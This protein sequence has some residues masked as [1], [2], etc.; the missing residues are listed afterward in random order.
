M[1][2]DAL[3]LTMGVGEVRIK[4]MRTLFSPK[5]AAEDKTSL[6]FGRSSAGSIWQFLVKFFFIGATIM[7]YQKPFM[8]KNLLRCVG[9]N[10]SFG[11]RNFS[12]FFV[13]KLIPISITWRKYLYEV[14]MISPLFPPTFLANFGDRKIQYMAK[15]LAPLPPPFL[16]K[17]F[18][19]V[20]GISLI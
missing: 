14:P 9:E 6:S 5:A 12:S 16:G 11:E 15:W 19:R 7:R 2:T 13:T 20:G 1:I 3:H 10:C 4:V 17:N 18:F 8:E